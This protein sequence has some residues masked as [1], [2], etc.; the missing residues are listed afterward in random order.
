MRSYLSRKG[1]Y[2]NEEIED[3]EYATEFYNGDT[4]KKVDTIDRL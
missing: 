2:N 3:D 1:F 4:V